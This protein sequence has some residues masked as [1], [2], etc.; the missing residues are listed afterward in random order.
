M[1]IPALKLNLVPPPTFWRHRHELIGWAAVGLGSVSLVLVMGLVW[2]TYREADKESQKAVKAVLETSKL[3][4][5]KEEVFNQLR[6]IDVSQEMPRWKLVERI[7]SERSMPWSRL[8]AELERCLAPDVRIR[9]VQRDRDTGGV[10]ILKLKGEAKSREAEAA[11]LENLHKN[12]V[13]VQVTLER[14]GERQG[15][16]W[17]FDC[18]L[19]ASTEPP[20]YT[21]LPKYATPLPKAESPQPQPQRSPQ[22][23][24]TVGQTRKAVSPS[25]VP[26]PPAILPPDARPKNPRMPT[27]LRRP[28]IDRRSQERTEASPE[29]SR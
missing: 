28:V 24:I 1:E 12:A 26:S 23:P 27:N 10:V 29:G 3:G 5:K 25:A 18:T 11:F 17:E 8:S 6:T 16:G 4:R 13:F 14:E 20:P 19:T 15:G 7:L 22:P 21:P 2:R 9:S